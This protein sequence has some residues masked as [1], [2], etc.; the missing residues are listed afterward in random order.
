[1]NGSMTSTDCSCGKKI[2]YLILEYNRVKQ[3]AED[4]PQSVKWSE[5]LKRRKHAGE[6]E[7]FD[8]KLLR[9][10]AYRPFYQVFLCQSPLFI[11][12]PGLA[13]ILFPPLKANRVI[14]FSDINSRTNYCVLAVDGLADL[15]FGAAVDG[16]QQLPR[17]RYFNG[18]QQDNIT[19]WAL[20][21]FRENYGATKPPVTKDAIFHYVYAVLHDPI[22]RERYW[23]NLKREFPR[24]PFHPDFWRWA[25]WGEELMALHIGYETVEPW[26][27]K[28]TDVK[29]ERS[30][31]AGLTPK[32]ML[33][34]D[35][36][37]GI[38]ILD[39]ET[40]L[41]GVPTLAWE[42]RLGN[43]SGLEWIFDQYKER[44][45]KGPT[46]RAKF[47]TYRFADY[48]EKVIRP[49]RPGVTR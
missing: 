12:R 18:D 15:H 36:D 30:A 16:Y 3:N 43:R 5:T 35:K 34:A 37:H 2:A 27:L 23:Q 14:C 6:E 22:Y 29:D 20:G 9:R 8:P 47:N 7:G 13:D 32:A 11:D 33:K 41:S 10:A 44:T 38:I 4:F 25:G 39:S 19:D 45:P 1:M 48:K 49:P 26:P 21:R 24:I 42:Y 28:R 17:F 46:I 40:Q 31:R